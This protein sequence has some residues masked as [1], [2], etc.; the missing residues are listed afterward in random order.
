V[1]I[2]SAARWTRMTS[3]SVTVRVW[4][5]AEFTVTAMQTPTRVPIADQRVLPAGDSDFWLLT[6]DSFFSI[7]IQFTNLLQ[8]TV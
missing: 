7:S 4:A 8:W 2:S 6:P 3:A 5:E 1:S